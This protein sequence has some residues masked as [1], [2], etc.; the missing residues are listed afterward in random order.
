MQI[1]DVI[2]KYRKD[3]KLTQE[4]MARRLGVTAPAVNKWEN[5]KSSPDISLLSPIARLFDISVDTLLNHETELSDAEAD[6]LIEATYE[7]LKTEPFD[8][9][10]QW[11]KER[12]EEYPNSHYLILRMTQIFGSQREMQESSG[13]EKYDDFILDCYRHVLDSNNEGLKSDAAESLYDFYIN[14][15][16]YDQAEECLVYFSH[17]N[18]ERKLKQ[19]WICSKTGRKE[20][21]HKMLDELLYAEY[22]S[23]SMTFNASYILALEESNLTKAHM[24]VEKMKK[25]AG[26]F[27]MGEYHEVSPALELAILEKNEEETLYIMERMITNTKSICDFTKSPLYS[28]MEFSEIDETYFAEVRED[29]IKGF[30]D[31]ETY[32]YL[33]KNPLWRELV[34]LPAQ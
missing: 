26:L 2:R 21:A 32:A 15:E 34:G 3:K 14:K 7:K 18:P 23:L 10:F 11:M 31:E 1:G 5:G 16:Q 9:V 19:A 24:L 29:L 22:Q 20:N 25:L 27:E 13:G 30:R 4:E 17:E 33:K 6:R 12:I 28:H 8:D